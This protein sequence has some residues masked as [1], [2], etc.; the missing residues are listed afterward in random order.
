MAVE[1]FSF[2]HMETFAVEISAP[3]SGRVDGFR[4]SRSRLLGS[5]QIWIGGGAYCDLS[6]PQSVVEFVLTLES[7]WLRHLR[8]HCAVS[9][10]ATNLFWYIRALGQLDDRFLTDE[11]VAAR[12]ARYRGFRVFPSLS[13]FNDVV[14]FSLET[15]NPR[16]LSLRERGGPVIET[17]V[18]SGVLADASDAMQAWLAEVEEKWKERFGDDPYFVP[19]EDDG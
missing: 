6:T 2:G 19:P 3:L 17:P 7:L 13:G 9:G 12:S 18:P 14:A 8:R 1:K 5:Y 16:I 11:Q 10:D 4:N 15:P